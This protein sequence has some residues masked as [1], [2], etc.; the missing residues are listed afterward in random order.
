MAWPLMPKVY[1][2]LGWAFEKTNKTDSAIQAYNKCLELKPDY[3]GA[4][5]Q[6]GYILY[7]KEDYN[8]ALE[9]FKKYEE[10]VK[11]PITDYLYWYRKGFS[12]NALK[13]YS[14]AKPALNKALELKADYSNTYLELGFA[15]SRLKEDEEG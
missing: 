6:L 7:N 12:Y 10:A 3:S 11:T 15:S 8:G 2:E 4:S 9:K 13:E 1:F 5:R 14:N